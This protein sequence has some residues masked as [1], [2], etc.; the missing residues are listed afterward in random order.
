[1]EGIHIVIKELPLGV[2][3]DI[4]SKLSVPVCFND[5]TGFPQLLCYSDARCTT[6]R[7]IKDY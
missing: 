5:K 3:V 6:E 2:V 7:P 4:L 1:M